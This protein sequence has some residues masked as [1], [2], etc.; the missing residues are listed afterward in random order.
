MIF[1]ILNVARTLIIVDQI[2]V[3]PIVLL[4]VLIISIEIIFLI[5]FV[6]LKIFCAI[7][8]KLVDYLKFGVFLDNMK[9][10]ILIK[11]K[12]IYP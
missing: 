10:F 2:F 5:L 11:N 12:N 9:F 3:I 6:V 8:K 4:A 7:H 1:L